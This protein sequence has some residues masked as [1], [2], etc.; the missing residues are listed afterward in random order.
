MSA[1]TLQRLE[2]EASA[3]LCIARN[4]TARATADNPNGI[5]LKHEGEY[6]SLTE[7]LLATFLQNHKKVLGYSSVHYP[8]RDYPHDCHEWSVTPSGQPIPW[9]R[10][11]D[12]LF[13]FDGEEDIWFQFQGK[14][15]NLW[16]QQLRK[17]LQ[18]KIK[19]SSSRSLY[20]GVRKALFDLVLRH[21]TQKLVRYYFDGSPTV[22]RPIRYISYTSVKDWIKN[23]YSLNG[24]QCF[25]LLERESSRF[26]AYC[27]D[28]FE[29]VWP[30]E[31]N[32]IT[33]TRN[34][35]R[36][37]INDHG[38]DF[39]LTAPVDPLLLTP[40][41]VAAEYGAWFAQVRRGER[42]EET[43]LLLHNEWMTARKKGFNALKPKLPSRFLPTVP[44][45]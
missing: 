2:D 22:I 12:I 23:D 41:E 25:D 8:E 10:D 19:A 35:L 24:E 21:E 5:D 38:F 3:G 29:A 26:I 4:L 20:L 16:F 44:P 34:R 28:F 32:L 40:K 13:R 33:T 39:F 36:D 27:Y 45:Y 7:D 42:F 43:E 9:V 11:F 1:V 6:R 31:S 17:A 18:H 37:H 14:G 30:R 15:Q